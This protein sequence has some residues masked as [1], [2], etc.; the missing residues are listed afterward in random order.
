MLKDS[1]LSWVYEHSHLEGEY[2]LINKL[3]T[4]FR[5]HPAFKSGNVLANPKPWKEF[6]GKMAEKPPGERVQLYLPI[7]NE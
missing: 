6:I 5:E 3:I 2:P 7:S 1:G 4:A